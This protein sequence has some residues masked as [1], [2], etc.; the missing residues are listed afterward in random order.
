MTWAGI[1]DAAAETLVTYGVLVLIIA[2]AVPFGWVVAVT[3]APLKLAELLFAISQNKWVIL[4][5]INVLLLIAGCFMETTAILLI[6]TPTLL[7]LVKQLGV[8]EVHFG[9]MMIINL[10]IGALTPPFGVLLFITMD[11]AKVSFGAIVRA[12]MPFYV[13][14]AVVLLLVTYWPDMVMF[15]PNLFKD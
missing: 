7:P 4:G 5:I 11:I 10:L 3:E 8:N 13:P 12:I 2:A 1:W 15:L 9:L 14:L 6:A